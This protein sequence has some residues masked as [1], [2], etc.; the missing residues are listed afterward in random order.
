MRINFRQTIFF[1]A[2]VVIFAAGCKKMTD[3]HNAVTDPS[4]KK[5]LL[6]LIDEN[7]D[8]ATFAGLLRQTGY[9]KQLIASKGYTVFA[10]GNNYFIGIDQAI[11]NDP[12]RLKKFIGNHIAGQ[13]YL[14]TAVTVMTRINMLNGK[15]NNM[16]RTTIEG[17]TI[18]TADKYASNGILQVINN[19]LP[20]RDNCWELM[21]NNL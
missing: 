7:P 8:L 5:N 10:P 13:A 15:Y 17:V 2:I 14:T 12:N 11:L 4:L 21:T 1:S 3:E 6:E 19:V 18:T 20:A 9:D 16:L